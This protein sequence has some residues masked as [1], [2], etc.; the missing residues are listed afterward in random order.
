MDVGRFART[1]L[2]AC[3]AL[4]A[5]ASRSSIA[6]D[7]ETKDETAAN[8][9]IEFR[10]RI[11]YAGIAAR[12]P[13]HHVWGCSP[14]K[15]DDGKYHLFGARFGNPFQTAWRSDSHV[16]HYVSDTPQGP[17]TFV[18]VVYRGERERKGQWNYFGIHNPCI[19]KV[20]GKYVLFFI[21][22]SNKDGKSIPGNQTI[23]MT[24]ADSVSGPWSEPGQVL[25][26]SDDPD[27]WTCQSGN[28]VCNPAFIKGLDGR[29]YLYYKSA[30]ARYG[31][32]VADKLEGPYIHHPESVTKNDKT[33]EDATACVWNGKVCLVTTDN[34]GTI[35]RGG[36]LLWQS[37]DGLSFGP[38]T[39]AYCTL[40][41]HVSQERYP[42]THSAKGKRIKGYSKMVRPQILMEDGRPAWLYAP[43]TACYQ[44][45][46]HTDNL[47][48][49]ILTDEEVKDVG[50]R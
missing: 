29:Y 28:G 8:D 3:L 35:Q 17:F 23:G 49:K 32:A 45:R 15:D 18:D 20:D 22:N 24:M 12:E 13:N 47:V 30:H 50:K 31:V 16:V 21:A 25:T 46:Q 33:I 34:H 7:N 9:T 39:R 42:R 26:P 41:R 27:H 4:M 43:S 44:G 40:D 37:D 19:K 11:Q 6:G 1:V 48:F 38:P 36:G 5:A 14:I 10:D 2:A